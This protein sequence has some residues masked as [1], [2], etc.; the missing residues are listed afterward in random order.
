MKKKKITLTQKDLELG[1]NELM[2]KY[3][4]SS[5]GHAR[6]VLQK[7]YFWENY[8][9]VEESLSPEWV[10]ENLQEIKKAVKKAVWFKASQKGVLRHRLF[11][12]YKEDLVQEGFLYVLKRAGEI[13][14]GK[15]KLINIAD[16]GIDHAIRKY[17]FYGDGIYTVGKINFFDDKSIK[18]SDSEDVSIDQLFSI[19]QEEIVSLFGEKVW[20]KV[21][22]WASGRSGRCP[23]D[24]SNVLKIV[25][26]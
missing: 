8:L 18:A 5:R 4:L 7:G 17:F 23:E 15:S 26:L 9:Q 11:N 21:W 22:S 20:S 19:V 14:S 3:G 13:Q 10:E 2:K 16:S 6:Y 24:V 12:H 25:A 1:P